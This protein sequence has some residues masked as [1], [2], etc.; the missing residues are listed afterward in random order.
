V[1]YH[2]KSPGGKG[3]ESMTTGEIIAI[4]F[5][6]LFGLAVIYTPFGL[7]QIYKIEKLKS[8]RADLRR[9]CVQNRLVK[10]KDIK[11]AEAGNSNSIHEKAL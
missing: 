11:A 1:V 7:Y 9:D 4:I 3:R 8:E 6:A 10:D 5:L 2:K